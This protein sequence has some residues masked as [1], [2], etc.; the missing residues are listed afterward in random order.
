MSL[1]SRT[2]ILL[3][4][5]MIGTH[6]LWVII[7]SIEHTLHLYS[8][9]TLVHVCH[10]QVCLISWAGMPQ[11]LSTQ[12]PTCI[13][14]LLRPHFRSFLLQ[15][16]NLYSEACVLPLVWMNIAG[17]L[18]VGSLKMHPAPKAPAFWST[19]CTTTE[20]FFRAAV[21]ELFSLHYG[22]CVFVPLSLHSAA[23]VPQLLH[24]CSKVAKP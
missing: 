15:L 5:S 21:L 20:P 9:H 22:A 13:L 6:V 10:N 12:Y 16:L 2:C 1:D 11:S 19:L 4:L 14:Q 8:A 23:S 17:I 24:P 7:C 3:L 18:K